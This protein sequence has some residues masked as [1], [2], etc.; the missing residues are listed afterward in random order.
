MKND[1]TAATRVRAF[2]FRAP[3][4]K[5]NFNFSLEITATRE[6]HEALCTNLSEDG[7]AAELLLKLPTK[8]EVTMWLLFPGGTTPVQIK[9]VVEYRRERL[10]GFNFLYSTI[11]EREQVKAFIQMIRA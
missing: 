10:H 4:F 7:L 6:R 5:T 9:A 11:D 3:R 2:G 1:G 8:T